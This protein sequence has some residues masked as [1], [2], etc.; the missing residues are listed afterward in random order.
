MSTATLSPALLTAEEYLR[1]PDSDRPT[2]LVRGRVVAMNVPKPRHG[3]VCSRVE[4]AARR[5]FE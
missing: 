4:A 2:E 5:F 3:Q 1:L